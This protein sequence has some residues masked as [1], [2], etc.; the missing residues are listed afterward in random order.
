MIDRQI[1]MFPHQYPAQ[2]RALLRGR[3]FPVFAP[4]DRQLSWP[5]LNRSHCFDCI[6]NQV[7]DDLLQLNTISLNGKRPLRKVG[8][9][10]DSILSNFASRQYGY[11]IDRPTE[12]KT[13]LSRRCFLAVVADPVDDGSAR[14]VSFT[15]QSSASLT[16]PRSGGFLSKK[17]KAALALLRTV[18]IVCVTS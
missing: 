10:R 3:H 14:S 4:C 18:A 17:F 1:E 5:L 13:I 7:Q 12:I 15:I 11:F 8:V 6:R 9:Y 16:S 2:Y